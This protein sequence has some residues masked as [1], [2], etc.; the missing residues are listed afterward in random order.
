MEIIGYHGTNNEFDK[1]SL[2]HFGLNDFG[3]LGKGIYLT[4]DFEMAQS[5]A[6][7]ETG[8]VL[9][10]KATINNPYI[11]NDWKYSYHPEKLRQE[12]N[13][14]NAKEI[15]N[16][17]IEQ[18]YDS[19]MLKYTDDY[20]E[21]F[22]ELCVFNTDNVKIKEELYETLSNMIEQVLEE[23]F[24]SWF[25]GSK[26]VDENGQPLIFY[27]GTKQKFDTFKS[28]YNDKLIFFAYDEKFAKEWAESAPL[29][30]EQEQIED[31]I[32]DKKI[33]P[34]GKA[35]YKKLNQKYG[36]EYSDEKYKEARKKIDR[37]ERRQHRLAGIDPKVIPVYIK[38]HK[39]F[40]PE[41]DYELVLDEIIKYY[42][43]EN[44][45]T[46]EYEQKLQTCLNNF[47]SIK[48]KEMQWYKDNPEASHEEV[49]EHQRNIEKAYELVSTQKSIKN[50]FDSHL[51]RI[52]KG[53]W[54]YFEHDSIINKIFDELG[55]DAIQLSETEG[56]LTTIAVR[57]GTNQIKSIYATE[58]KDSSN[59]Y[60]NMKQLNEKIES[61]L[62]DLED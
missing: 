42:N 10:V 61:F 46:L 29:T 36:D 32:Y 62:R 19:V 47:E 31:D 50:D 45:Y 23:D 48:N 9:K 20:G 28:K 54:I 14:K 6:D 58:F 5:Y 2:N 55:Y 49:V 21:E 53:S 37:Y 1:F 3:Y 16:K 17:L 25:E 11:L 57:E 52:K 15:N 4:N 30:D 43:W 27:H 51:K 33:R 12:L 39:I 35:V 7:E 44:P 38:A 26:L 40:S 59:I 60:E 22:M 56:K 8:R 34:Y 24:K 13:C 41:R 18:G